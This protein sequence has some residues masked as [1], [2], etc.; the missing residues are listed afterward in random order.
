MLE[1]IED[2]RLAR[3]AVK[4]SKSLG[5][6]HKE[7]KDPYRTEFQRDW[8]RLIHTEAF[9]KLEFKTQV[10]MFSEAPETSRN[11]LTHSIEVEQIS[12][13]LARCLGLNEDLVKA[14]ALAHDFG[15]PPFG[16]SGEAELKA[17]LMEKGSDF[18]HNRQG[19]KIVTELEKRAPSYRGL[20]LTLE[21]LEGFERHKTPY[22][23]ES[24]PIYIDARNASLECQAVNFADLIAYSS[25]DLDDAITIHV[26]N[27]RELEKK[28]R[29]SF[30]FMEKILKSSSGIDS[31]APGRA[32]AAS[33]IN[34]MI[35][36]V[37]K[38]TA[39]RIKKYKIASIEDVRNSSGEH[40]SFSKRFRDQ[41]DGL[42][43]FIRERFYNDYRVVR[44]D[45]KGR[46]IIRKLFEEYYRSPSIIPP[47]IQNR[48]SLG[49]KKHEV[50]ADHIAGMTDREALEEYKR[51]FELSG[52]QK[53][54]STV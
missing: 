39:K 21:V 26:I 46:R 25:H 4:S 36:D 6:V 5:R 16:H 42:R 28:S 18:N 45:N 17:I 12:N 11:R 54:F 19:L 50:I 31:A 15:H 29:Q 22:D 10:L 47:P 38:E 35:K 33:F 14:I 52:Y 20:N 41:Q 48:L 27:A 7:A 53:E 1:K 49:E 40:F 23:V 37:I 34:H 32:I 9:R 13:T 24:S 8:H 2:K 3:Y 51:I 44:M 43:R 30:P